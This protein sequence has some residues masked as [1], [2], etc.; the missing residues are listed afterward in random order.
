M[1]QG[2]FLVRIAG[3]L[4][5]D[6]REPVPEGDWLPLTSGEPAPIQGACPRGDRHPSTPSAQSKVR[7]VCRSSCFS[8]RR[9]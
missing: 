4:K 3:N 2:R 8:S 1:E 7:S 5:P 6:L 9:I